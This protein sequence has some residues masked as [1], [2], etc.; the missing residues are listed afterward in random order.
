MKV[1]EVGLAEG[2][3]DE[4]YASNVA[5]I[6]DR[7]AINEFM[8]MNVT[9]TFGRITQAGAAMF[10]IAESFNRRVAAIAAL[11]VYSKANPS[12]SIEQK[13]AYAREMVRTTQFEYAK[14]N[15]P[16][17]FRGPLAVPF[18]FQTYM[19]HFLYLANP[20]LKGN[21]GT[22]ARIWVALALIAGAEGLPLFGSM[23]DMWDL[24]S[25]WFNKDPKSIRQSIKETVEEL[26]PEIE[27]APRIAL[28]GLGSQWGLGPAHA[29]EAMNFLHPPLDI[30]LPN[31][32]ISGSVSAGYLHRGLE[33]IAK[34]D[35]DPRS[36]WADFLTQ[37][38]GPAAAIPFNV[39]LA[40]KSDEPNVLKRYERAMPTFMRGISRAGRWSSQGEVDVGSNYSELRPMNDEW[41]GNMVATSL[42]FTPAPWSEYWE[43]KNLVEEQRNYWQS[44][45]NQLLHIVRYNVFSEKPDD[46]LD[47]TLEDIK[48]FNNQVRRAG[49]PGAVISRDTIKDSIA[50]GSRDKVLREYGGTGQKMWAP[51]YGPLEEFMGEAPGM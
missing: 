29:L 34:Q 35:Q 50:R 36:Q 12:A 16:E 21:F 47:S 48:K 8:P 51:L 28:N 7:N 27:S 37:T 22:A 3:L 25:K 30:N 11:D 18:I 17:L 14:T 44:R 38:L 45:R 15:R 2:W 39:W 9:S 41:V 10:H 4:S 26:L 20:F 6:A 13:V 23:F 5:G 46:V 31:V 40:V 42:G 19:Q 32:D 24:M 49:I 43:T 33:T 1:I